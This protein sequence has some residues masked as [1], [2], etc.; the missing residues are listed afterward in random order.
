MNQKDSSKPIKP[1]ALVGLSASESSSGSPFVEK[2]VTS[3]LQQKY[4]S[5]D[6]LEAE[7]QKKETLIERKDNELAQRLDAMRQKDNELLKKDAEIRYM[8]ASKF[9]KLRN[10][11]VSSGLNK[12]HPKYIHRL[13]WSKPA[14]TPSAQ[15]FALEPGDGLDYKPKVTVVVP[16]YNHA[17]YLKQRLESIYMQTYNNYE[18]ILLDDNSPD[19]SQEILKKYGEKYKFI[20]RCAFNRENSGNIFSQWKRGIG[21][22]RGE[23]IWIAESDDFCDSNFLEELVKRFSDQSVMLA[24]A[25]PEFVDENGS[26]ASFTFDSYVAEL[27]DIKWADSYVETAH[28]EVKAGLGIKNTIPNVSGVV[29]RNIPASEFDYESLRQFKVC[30]DWY[31]YLSIIRGGRLAFVRETK[32]YYRF[33]PNN[34]S[35]NYQKDIG[36]VKEYAA[37]AKHLASNYQVTASL[38]SRNMR[39][40]QTVWDTQNPGR[41][42]ELYEGYVLA[43]AKSELK[44]RKPNILMVVYAFTTGGG[45]TV[46][47]RL[48]NKLKDD[49]YAITVF[50]FA[51]TPPENQ[52]TRNMLNKNIPV[53]ANDNLDL[54]GMLEDFGIELIHSHHTS[55]DVFFAR[56]GKKRVP[57]VVTTHGLYETLSDVEAKEVG[58]HVKSVNYWVY[59]ASKNLKSLQKYDWFR[60]RPSKKLFNAVAP[61]THA[62]KP[63]TRKGMGIRDDAF[64]LCLVSRAIRTKGWYE[65][66]DAVRIVNCISKRHV[67]LLLVGDGPLYEQFKPQMQD[68][69]IRLLG[70]REN[71]SDYYSVADMGLLP[72]TFPGESFPLVLIECLAVQ[73]PFIGTDIGEI[74]SMLTLDDGSVAGEVLSLDH[75]MVD[76]PELARAILKFSKSEKAYLAAQKNAVKLSERY[77][78]DP[79]AAQYKR[80]YQEVIAEAEKRSVKRNNKR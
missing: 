16:C 17:K 2:L 19:N 37:I 45:E 68:S 12:L 13:L 48:A 70:F 53:V 55:A 78:M 3:I 74:K 61:P 31:F 36:F 26:K 41:E 32:N 65:A 49:G 20:T 75:G 43:D 67:V 39:A 56:R 51:P 40:V 4:Q 50:E 14:D 30:G 72:S 52:T 7:L 1:Q 71:L 27:S 29:F 23:L 54:D 38:L 11:Y 60:H 69:S 59:T 76:V 63:V 44:L 57:H 42:K 73:K 21:M 25:Y 35:S 79:I 62:D 8:Q 18:V 5:I 6:Y 33:H 64:V 58:Q 15:A 9:W 46:P 34:T 80:I 77:A 24:Y 22:A 10:L 66:I 28:R 47:I